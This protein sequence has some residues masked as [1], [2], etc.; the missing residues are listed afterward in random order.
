MPAKFLFSHHC[1]KYSWVI[2]LKLILEI[3]KERVSVTEAVA[4][5]SLFFTNKATHTQT[6]LH[7]FHFLGLFLGL[8]T[9]PTSKVRTF[10]LGLVFPSLQLLVTE[11]GSITSNCNDRTLKLY[12]DL[13]TRNLTQIFGQFVKYCY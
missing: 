1:L 10:F 8:V 4:L 13:C 2:K 5:T 11:S 7:R 6:H 3:L 9:L 12:R